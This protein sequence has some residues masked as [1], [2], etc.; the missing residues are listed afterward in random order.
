MVKIV[1]PPKVDITRT[2]IGHIKA[3]GEAAKQV[4][5][6]DTITIHYPRERRKYPDNFRGL[7]IFTKDECISCFRCAHICPANAIQM[8]PDENGRYYPAVD[9]AKCILCHFCVDS[10]PTGALKPSKIHDVAFKDVESMFIKDMDGI[11]EIDREDKKL[12]E[13]DFEDDLKITKRKYVENLI[14]EVPK[15]PRPKMIAAVKSPE[16]CIGCRLCLQSCPV[17]AISSKTEGLQVILETDPNK[18]TGCG[19]C[20]RICP[21]DVLVLQPVKEG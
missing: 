5:A 20:V 7:M 19:I 21:T 10:C 3:I 4:V 14:V 1:K 16:N 13:Y 11:P 9:Y 6:P 8:I 18:C 12:V 2:V 15:P 17:D